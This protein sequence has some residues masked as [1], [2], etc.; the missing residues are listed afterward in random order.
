MDT[1]EPAV[2]WSFWVTTALG[3]AAVALSVILHAL[4]VVVLMETTSPFVEAFV[5][6]A[7]S[8]G[9]VGGAAVIVVFCAL[10]RRLTLRRDLALRLPTA[11]AFAAWLAAYLGLYA[12]LEVVG[13]L[14]QPNGESAA[15]PYT[16][17]EAMVAY[18]IFAVVAA[19]LFEEILF[20]GFLHSGWSRSRLGV[21]G[22]ILLTS[23]LWAAMHLPASAAAL[24]MMFVH[25]LLLGLARHY[26]GSL[27]VPLGMHVAHNLA[28]QLQTWL[29][30]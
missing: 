14:L 27:Y 5:W 23:G 30:G 25:G 28:V 1:E 17:V 16:P 8:V 10:R 9:G 3:V 4:T 15:S 22:T 18:V 2:P 21:P 7:S 29:T 19:P 11:T 12:L 6:V 24:T 20:R 26:S 13:P